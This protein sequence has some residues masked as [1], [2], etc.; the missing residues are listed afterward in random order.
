MWSRTSQLRVK[1]RHLNVK[2]L[3]HM[4]FRLR[5][6]GRRVYI[7][8]LHRGAGT[9]FRRTAV[10]PRAPTLCARECRGKENVM[11]TSDELMR[12]ARACANRITP[13]RKSRQFPSFSEVEE[14]CE[15]EYEELLGVL[16]DDEVYQSADLAVQEQLVEAIRAALPEI[17]HV[18]ARGSRRQPGRAGLAAAGGRLS[19]RDGRRA[20]ARRGRVRIPED[21]EPVDPDELEIEDVLRFGRGRRGREVLRTQNARMQNA[22][23]AT[24]KA[25]LG[26]LHPASRVHPASCISC[27]P[28]SS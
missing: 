10:Q 3:A 14:Q 8:A 19:P 22:R 26:A 9:S 28:P 4:E 15:E 23:R 18:L 16:H 12:L 6:R 27:R 5:I 7:L 21:D 24:A 17:R 2:S 25:C 11:P 1:V 13:P 20:E